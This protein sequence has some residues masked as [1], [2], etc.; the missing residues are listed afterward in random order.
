V[1][2][3]YP[4]LG[5]R[6]LSTPAGPIALLEASGGPGTPALL[7]PGYTGSKEDFALILTPLARTGR[8]VVAMDQRGQYESPGPED[9]AAYTIEALAAD[10]RAVMADLAGPRGG[11]VHL[12]GHSFGGLVARGAVLADPAA[13]AS[14]TLLCS[15]P[16]AIDGERRSRMEALRP[17]LLTGGMAAVYERLEL[18]AAGDAR[19]AN[20]PPEL[21]EFLRRRFLASSPIGLEAMGDAL[22][23]EPDR[24]EALRAT[25]VPVLV[26]YGEGDDSWTPA[27]QADM[28]RRLSARH[29]V[30][31]GAAHSPAVENPLTTARIVAEFW[32]GADPDTPRLD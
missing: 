27:V 10:V 21:K 5:R 22:A 14:L 13:V 29:E 6:D 15:G 25:G 31:G 3:A 24:V 18:L 2:D 17:L 11:P 9:P 19:T 4:S 32:S 30:I 1:T 7:V 26:A 20:L 12:L 23:G 16:A 8:R 28:A